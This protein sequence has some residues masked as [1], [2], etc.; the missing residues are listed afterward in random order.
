[1]RH[2]WI[3]IAALLLALPGVALATPAP[4]AFSG[5]NDLGVPRGE[6]RYA[7]QGL[8]LLYHRRYPDA[9]Q[10]FEEASLDYPDS[11]LAPLGRAL[12]YQAWMYENQDF[13]WQRV[14]EQERADTARLLQQ[15]LRSGHL[16]AWTLFMQGTHLGMDAMHDVRTDNYLA[17]FNK[18]WEAV[19]AMKKVERLAPDFAEVQ[20]ALGLYNY[21][22][23][24]LADQV[25]F[26][27]DAGDQREAG[28]AQMKYARDHGTLASGPAGLALAY[29]YFDERRYPE[30]IAEAERVMADYPGSVI[31]GL[32]LAR[33]YRRERQHARA[34][35][36]LAG[37]RA[38]SPDAPLVR[39]ELAQA[40]YRSRRWQSA[41]REFSNFLNTRPGA[42]RK[43]STEYRLAQLARRDR[44]WTEALCW[45]DSALQT[46]P[47]Y[48]AARRLRS[49]I[50]RDQR[51]A[52]AAP[53]R[54]KQL[55]G[56]SGGFVELTSP[57]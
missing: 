3:L 55:R 36:L 9:L 5:E 4:S 19:Q 21:W 37:L 34:V 8:D 6:F 40:L 12:V 30:A 15:R 48:S 23:S 11:P 27:P 10:L 29:S 25:S 56:K 39:Y 17:A 22:R 45:A 1:M 28:I 38:S 51:R 41:R 16:R 31:T 2:T 47:D 42:R 13:A 18:G 24:A 44:D 32:T 57:R 43:A 54:T 33:L 14:Y 52:A 35:D 26:L 7:Q 46:R 49:R 20:L 53:R 50:V